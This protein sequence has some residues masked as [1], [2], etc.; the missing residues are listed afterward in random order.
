MSFNAI[1]QI[2]DFSICFE[3]PLRLDFG[4]FPR[5][6]ANAPPEASA[7][8]SQSGTNPIAGSALGFGTRSSFR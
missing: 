4:R 7:P 1:D 2:I 8:I 6:A 3:A 5:L